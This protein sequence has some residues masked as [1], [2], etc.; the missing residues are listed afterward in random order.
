M[1]PNSFKGILFVASSRPLIGAM[2]LYFTSYTKSTMG[3]HLYGVL[4]KTTE[5]RTRP[6]PSIGSRGS[7][8]EYG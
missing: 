5:N 8:L 1:Y 4:R 3:D 6:Q 2:T 7:T